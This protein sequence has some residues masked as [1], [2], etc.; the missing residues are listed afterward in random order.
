VSFL[1]KLVPFQYYIA[2]A[3]AAGLL[4]ALGAQ[5]LRVNIYRADLAE[6]ISLRAQEREIS[7]AAARIQSEAYR[8]EDQR[9]ASAIRSVISEAIKTSEAVALDANSARAANDRLRERV[10]ALVARSR[11]PRNPA[12]PSG[13]PPAGDAADV[14]ADML[15][16]VS[17]AARQLALIADERGTAGL[18]CER[19]YEALNARP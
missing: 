1:L 10:A 11:A 19:S 13:S 3:V 8:I 5:T 18:A 4:L 14:L 17:E 6:S 2:A 9:R 15:G 12:A 16:R 7:A